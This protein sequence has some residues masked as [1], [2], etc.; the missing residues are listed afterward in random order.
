MEE[1][2]GLYTY[3]TINY[4]VI[5]AKSISL[6]PSS[7]ML[8][9]CRFWPRL[10]RPCWARTVYTGMSRRLPGAVLPPRLIPS[11]MRY[12]RFYSLEPDSSPLNTPNCPTD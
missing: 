11:Q 8:R 2:S 4:A 10:A 12:P 7:T 6:Q 3:R 1:E 5:G 9:C